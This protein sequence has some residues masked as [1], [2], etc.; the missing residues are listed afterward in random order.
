MLLPIFIIGCARSGTSILGEF[1][2]NN[3]QCEYFFDEDVWVPNFDNPIKKTRSKI[4]RNTKISANKPLR[5]ILQK[6]SSS[7]G[8]S[9]NEEEN[10][11]LIE[12]DVTDIFSKQVKKFLSSLSKERLV[13]HGP[14]HSLRIPFI[15]KLFPNSKFLH[16]IR[17]GRD[18][19]CSLKRGME[20]SLWVYHKPPGWKKYQ[21]KSV[22][23]KCAWLWNE[24]INIIYS[25]KQNLP[26]EDYFEI[27][28][29]ELV[30]NPEKTMKAVFEFFGIPFEKNQEELCKKVQDEMS[31]S[32][33]S[34]VSEKWTVKNHKKRIGRYKENLSAQELESVEAILGQNNSKLN[35]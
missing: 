19:T 4:I 14:K 26:T 33:H 24:T 31:D 2:E 9:N 30:Q 3:S 34:K 22:I 25:D 18:V 13:I 6:I 16:I 10:E 29:G 35:Y 5:Q 32:Y 1:F 12:K 20:D 7:L 28:Y 8:R 15:K 11:R 21:S 27:R 23:E 17:D